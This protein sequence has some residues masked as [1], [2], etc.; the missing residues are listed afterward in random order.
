[1]RY[2]ALVLLV[3]CVQQR[4]A[5]C[6]QVCAREYECVTST[7]S[8]VPFDEKECIAACA[9]LEADPDNLA[10]V[11]KHADCVAKHSVCSEVLDCQ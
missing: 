6:K 4:S 9:V 3:A 8:S 2:L 7:S 11:Q 1:M 10:K 5:R